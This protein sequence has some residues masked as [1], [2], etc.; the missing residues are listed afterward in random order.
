MG[1][2]F[3]CPQIQMTLDDSQVTIEYSIKR[4]AKQKEAATADNT[5]TKTYVSEHVFFAIM[6][7][8]VLVVLSFLL[9]VILQMYGKAYFP[10]LEIEI[11]KTKAALSCFMVVVVVVVYAFWSSIVKTTNRAYSSV[12]SKFLS[13]LRKWVLYWPTISVPVCTLVSVY[14]NAPE[15]EF[16]TMIRIIAPKYCRDILLLIFLFAFAAYWGYDY[17]KTLNPTKG[18][19]AKGKKGSTDTGVSKWISGIALGSVAVMFVFMMYM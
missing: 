6:S 13:P 5:G 10:T 11:D 14:K 18:K 15:G 8:I 12:D 4:K 16:F 17:Y 3:D 2:E 7:K 9:L 19:T 1:G